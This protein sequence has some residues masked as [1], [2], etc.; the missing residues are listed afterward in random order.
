MT[1]LL[2]THREA[3]RLEHEN[4]HKWT[5]FVG[6]ISENFAQRISFVSTTI[7]ALKRNTSRVNMNGFDMK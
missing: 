6:P 7:L 1:F 3:D 5:L 4:L 2:K